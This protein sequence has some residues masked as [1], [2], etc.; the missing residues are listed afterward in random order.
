MSKVPPIFFGGAL[1]APR[2]E[3]NDMDEFFAKFLDWLMDVS[4]D[5][6]G[7][8]LNRALVHITPLAQRPVAFLLRSLKSAG[9]ESW[10][11]FK[12]LPLWGKALTGGWTGPL[13]RGG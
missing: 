8:Q 10:V 1:F 6:A 2:V 11:A 5:V 9:V 7:G 4:S 12:S 13:S 3:S